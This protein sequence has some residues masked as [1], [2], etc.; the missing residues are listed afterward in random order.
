MVFHTVRPRIISSVLLCA[1]LALPGA[2]GAQAALFADP[3]TSNP[4]T[5]STD[6]PVNRGKKGLLYRFKYQDAGGTASTAGFPM[7]LTGATVTVTVSTNAPVNCSAGTTP[8]PNACV[9]SAADGD[10]ED[11]VL[12]YV[13]IKYGS[14]FP[15]NVI[16]Q[17]EVK[18]ARSSP[19]TG[20]LLQDPANTIVSFTTTTSTTPAPVRT[21]GIV[22]LVFDISGSMSLKAAPSGSRT[23]MEVL[24]TAAEQFFALLPMAVVEGDKL[25]AVYFASNATASSPSLISAFNESQRLQLLS[26]IK[27]RIPTTAT[28]MGAGLTVARPILSGDPA[29]RKYVLLFSDGEQNTMP[30]IGTPNSGWCNSTLDN[31]LLVGGAAYTV[32][33][34]CPIMA[35]QM[36]APGWI[37]QQKIGAL[38][39]ENNSLKIRDGSDT[40]AGDD[41]QTFF[42][43][44]LTKVFPGDKLEKVLDVS[45]AL[46][47]NATATQRFFAGPRD[48]SMTISVAWVGGG[49]GQQFTLRAPDGTM[50]DLSKR[51]DFGDGV[52]TARLRLPIIQNNVLIQTRGEW[53]IGFASGPRGPFGYHAIVLLDNEILS[54]DFRVATRDA[55]TGEPITLEVQLTE[56]GAPVTGATVGVQ[57]SGPQQGLGQMLAT[58]P[59]PSGTAPASSDPYRDDA[60]RKVAMLANDP[61]YAN[62]FADRTLPGMSLLDDGTG[63]DATANDGIYTGRLAATT[64]EGHYQFAFSARASTTRSGDFQRSWKSVTFVRAKPDAANT[65]MTVL[66]STPQAGAV[67][68]VLQVTP[69]DRFGNLLGPGYAGYMTITPSAGTVVTPLIDRLNGSYEVTVSVP[70]GQ[71]NPT[72]DIAV[73][74]TPVTSKPLVPLGS[75]LPSRVVSLHAGASV[76]QSPLSGAFDGALSLGI[77]LEMRI[78]RPFSIEAYLGHDRFSPQTSGS[79][80]AL[81]HLSLSG[82]ATLGSAM[83][84]PA[85]EA[86]VGGYSASGA[87][88]GTHFGWSAGASVQYW[89]QATR[90]ADVSY[91][92]RS[93]NGGDWEF[94]TIQAGVRLGF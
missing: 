15:V 50:I 58:T 80:F 44:I 89:F 61:A 41:M 87:G 69:K 68:H 71:A 72:I 84:R 82:K 64:V 77:D 83:L 4:N 2:V 9:F 40:F 66:S 22:E 75:S 52:T 39:C 20:S 62:L 81:T 7:T 25:G 67:L 76:P 5:G 88:S 85:I 33:S 65:V 94:A 16:V 57:L 56:S 70:S 73:L 27:S 18:G 63:G 11:G 54:S 1:T 36:S 14:D 3:L 93:A 49:S 55:G 26:D 24:Q 8:A 46:G 48:I 32:A 37:L 6:I 90:A 38:A 34:V 21:P 29:P 42:A 28:S 60:A 17:Y 43:Q 45:G 59:M 19:A 91:R 79:D 86:G 13:E 51:L 78:R 30:C 12:D 53:E 23:R 31:S 47:P 74:G 92:F 35:G 10:T